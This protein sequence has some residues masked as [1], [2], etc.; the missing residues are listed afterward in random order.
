MY[1]LNGFLGEK[2]QRVNKII[3][4]YHSVQNNYINMEAC[5]SYP[6]ESVIDAQRYPIF[7]LPTE[8][9][10]G[11]RFFPAFECIEDIDIYSEELVRTLFDLDI[12][13]NVTTQPH[14]GTQANQIVYNAVLSENDVVL[15]L[16]PKD[17][18]HISH[19]KISKNQNK[20]INYHL[21]PEFEF[22]YD[23]IEELTQ[24]NKPKLIIVGAS[25]YPLQIDY[26]RI[27]LIAHKYNAFLLADICH[28]ALYVLGKTYPAVFPH[29]DFVTFTMDKTLR[30][31]QGG[32]LIYKCEFSKLIAYSIF[33]IS[34]GGPLQSLQFAKMIAL[35]ELSSINLENYAKVVQDNSKIICK[36]LVER[37]ITVVTGTS[38]T[39][40]ILIDVGALKTTGN[41]V[42]SRFYENN[43]LVNKNLIP[44]DQTSPDIT[45]GIRLGTVCI[46]NLNYS[47]EDVNLLAEIIANILLNPAIQNEGIHYL[48]EKYH[49]TINISN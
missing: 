32:I 25:S 39:H 6:F 44:G 15:S 45:S 10:S 22:N 47:N 2:Y 48:V 16:S 43:V 42:E 13:Y 27:A 9:V 33:P 28:T 23:E 26:N 11:S 38:N 46:S 4:S 49:K 40:L 24:K 31:P 1:L 29:A 37:N 7:T 21:T 17:G 5:C 19:N 36:K 20:V 30:G 34:Q 8:G 14:S 35:V 12:N 18:G 3:D 41:L